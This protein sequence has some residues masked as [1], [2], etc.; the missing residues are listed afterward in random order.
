MIYQAWKF[1]SVVLL[2]MYMYIKMIRYKDDL[3][4]RNCTKHESYLSALYPQR[5]WLSIVIRDSLLLLP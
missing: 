3:D 4:V 2:E 1:C 5:K